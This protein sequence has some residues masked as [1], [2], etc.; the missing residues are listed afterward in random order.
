MTGA[1]DAPRGIGPHRAEQPVP[2]P[3][4]VLDQEERHE[5][6]QHKAAEELRRDLAAGDY[7][8]LDEDLC[9]LR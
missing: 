7:G 1:V 3:F 8:A 9:L 5:K 2:D 4:P 6:H